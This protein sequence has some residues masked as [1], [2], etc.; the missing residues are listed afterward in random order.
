MGTCLVADCL[1][2]GSLVEDRENMECYRI[3]QEQ[4][5]RM[6]FS[7]VDAPIKQRNRKDGCA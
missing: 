2:A 1:V 3:R 6:D 5:E 4:N 7:K